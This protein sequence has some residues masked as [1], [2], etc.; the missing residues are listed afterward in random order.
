MKKTLTF[1]GALFLTAIPA[2]SQTSPTLLDTLSKPEPSNEKVSHQ[3]AFKICSKETDY[4]TL[5]DYG[6]ELANGWIYY[7]KKGNPAAVSQTKRGTKDT[8]FSSA[9]I[10]LLLSHKYSAKDVGKNVG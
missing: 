9:F 1:I 10:G 5:Y 7:K 8:M 3:D 6:K 4:N 2:Y